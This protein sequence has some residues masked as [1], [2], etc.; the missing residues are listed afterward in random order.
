MAQGTPELLK[1]LEKIEGIDP[2]SDLYKEFAAKV[3]RRID[4]QK[5][6]GTLLYG[7]IAKRSWNVFFE[8]V[9]FQQRG[10]NEIYVF[11]R[12]RG[13]KDPFYPNQWHAPGSAFRPMENERMVADRLGLEFGTAIS[14]FEYL[15]D[16]VDWEK[17][18]ER[19]SGISRVYLTELD[20]DPRLDERHGWFPVTQLPKVTVESH[21]T[22]II[23]CALG[24]FIAGCS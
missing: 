17:G 3:L 14:N 6:F 10:P 24:A 1:L 20:G 23:P 11:L 22:K 7:E 4:P 19:G 21:L 13:E 9:V 18:E 15:D 2:Q 16:V 8:A 12:K 5:P